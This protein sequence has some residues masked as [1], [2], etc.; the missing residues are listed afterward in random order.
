MSKR[1]LEEKLTEVL[2]FGVR[3]HDDVTPRA[4]DGAAAILRRPDGTGALGGS[5][6][7]NRLIRS[8]VLYP[9]SYERW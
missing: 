5:R 9:L 7:P 8:Q 1:E 6:T 2:E 3:L 4:E